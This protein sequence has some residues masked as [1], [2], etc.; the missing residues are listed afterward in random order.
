MPTSKK[1]ELTYITLR[2]KRPMSSE[3]LKMIGE[4]K[5]TATRIW[6]IERQSLLFEIAVLAGDKSRAITLLRKM[7]RSPKLIIESRNGVPKNVQ[8]VPAAKR[9]KRRL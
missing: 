4:I 2:V 3:E 8:K 5:D 9:K 1:N 6:E 7:L